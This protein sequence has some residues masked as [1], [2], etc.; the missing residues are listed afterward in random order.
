[1]GAT[2]FWP[3]EDVFTACKPKF[4]PLPRTAVTS[5]VPFCKA[6]ALVFSPAWSSA[7]RHGHQ[8]Q[9]EEEE[10]QE[11]DEICP[12]L[13]PTKAGPVGAQHF[14]AHRRLRK[15]QAVQ[16]S[17]LCPCAP[18]LQA[19]GGIFPWPAWPAAASPPLGPAEVC[20]KTWGLVSTVAC[21]GISP[22]HP[23]HVAKMWH[24]PLWHCS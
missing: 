2:T 13:I 3:T 23:V 18:L 5:E 9:G 15:S 16:T 1:M 17:R 14:R 24:S 20:S 12:L 11:G 19:A 21:T 8:T 7:G 22:R 6:M 4:S 10:L